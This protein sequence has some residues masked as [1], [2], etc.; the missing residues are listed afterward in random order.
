MKWPKNMSGV[1]KNFLQGLLCKDPNKRLTWPHLA[2]HEFVKTGIKS[3]PMLT[4]Y[5]VRLWPCYMGAM[6]HKYPM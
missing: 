2:D 1:F 6:S 5:R 3:K 4:E